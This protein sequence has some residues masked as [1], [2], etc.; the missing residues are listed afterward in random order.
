MKATALKA[1]AVKSS[2]RIVGGKRVKKEITAE[3]FIFPV[4]FIAFLHYLL[5]KWG[6]PTP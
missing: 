5:L 3:T 4:L 2:T 1:T 6:L